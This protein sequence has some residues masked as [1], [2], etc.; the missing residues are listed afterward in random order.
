MTSFVE[1]SASTATRLQLSGVLEGCD[2]E[3]VYANF[4]DADGICAWWPSEA[5]VDPVV[6]GRLIAR[7]PS[8]GWTMR[9]RYT[10]LVQNR[11]IGF[12]WS[13]DHEPDTPERNVRVR[14]EAVE[15]GTRLTL[16]H[17]DYGSEDADERKGHLEGWLHFLPQLAAASMS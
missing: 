5:E 15:A 2:H 10:D 16:T 17:G 1:T 9:G 8:M 14:I 11:V 7:W 6:G 12:T 4:I 13:W 3:D